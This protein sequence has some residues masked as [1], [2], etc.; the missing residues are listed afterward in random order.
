MNSGPS[1][2][3][4]C[5]RNQSTPTA[6]SLRRSGRPYPNYRFPKV[7]RSSPGREITTR[8]SVCSPPVKETTGEPPVLFAPVTN[9][10]GGI[11]FAD[12]GAVVAHEQEQ[13]AADLPSFASHGRP[14]SQLRSSTRKAPPWF[15]AMDRN[16]DLRLSRAEFLGSDVDFDRLDADGDK[17]ISPAEASRN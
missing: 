5:D 8:C 2:I 15:L 3:D 13:H 4:L 9:R 6:A 7:F 14:T 10:R 12:L 17:A 16:R 11:D 1:P